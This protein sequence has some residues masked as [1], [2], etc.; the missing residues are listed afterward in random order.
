ML[1]RNCHAQANANKANAH[2]YPM[3]NDKIS[4]IVPQRWRI[5]RGDGAGGR[6]AAGVVSASEG[7]RLRLESEP[8]PGDGT[9]PHT[10]R[11][12]MADVLSAGT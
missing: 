7:A 12:F 5:D 2:E 1:M 11:F 4:I 9:S 6:L 10:A 8:R 3:F